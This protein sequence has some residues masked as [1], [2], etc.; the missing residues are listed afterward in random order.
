MRGGLIGRQTSPLSVL[1]E[2]T[3]SDPTTAEVAV[4]VDVTSSMIEQN[5]FF[6]AMNAL[7]DFISAMTNSNDSTLL[8][9]RVSIVPFSSRIN[10]GLSNADFFSGPTPNRWT[11]AQPYDRQWRLN[12]WRAQNGERGYSK[13]QYNMWLGCA[14]PAMDVA[15]RDGNRI[16]LEPVSPSI[17]PLTYQDDNVDSTNAITGE[18]FCPPPVTPLTNSVSILRSAIDDMTS[19][20]A[21]RLDVGLMGGWET[22]SPNFAND[23]PTARGSHA[24]VDQ[25]FIVFMSDGGMNPEEN[26]GTRH[27]DWICSGSDFDLNQ[28]ASR[29]ACRDFTKQNFISICNNIKAEGIKIFTIAYSRNAD[30]EL[31][32]EC[33]S[34]GE[35]FYREAESGNVNDV[36]QAIARTIGNYTIRLSR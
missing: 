33:A 34:D 30:A 18:S 32:S 23:W 14:E 26:S 10:Y 6:P 7:D 35:E 13:R 22:L 29:N 24:S 25:K 36:Y 8:K 19:Q 2:V 5:R 17:V 12:S 21:T 27:F 1:S 3:L 9:G 31:M 16:P 20:G 28:G 15:A 4:V 11:V